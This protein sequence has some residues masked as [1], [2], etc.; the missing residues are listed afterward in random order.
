MNNSHRSVF[1]TKKSTSWRVD[2]ANTRNLLKKIQFYTERQCKAISKNIIKC[3]T[4]A[5]LGCKVKVSGGIK[6][7]KKLKQCAL[8][9]VK[10]LPFK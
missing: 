1:I 10:F 8:V 5:K 4:W 9:C 7:V 3:F 6:E 2:A